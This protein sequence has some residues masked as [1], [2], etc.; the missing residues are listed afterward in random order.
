MRRYN[1]FWGLIC[2]VSSTLSGQVGRQ[3]LSQAYQLDR[4]GQFSQLI[5]VAKPLVDDPSLSNVERG[6]AAMLL[7][8]AYHQEGKFQDSASAYDRSL[9]LLGPSQ[10]N[11]LQ[12]AATLIAYG[13]LYHDM[14]R[15]GDA[16][17]LQLKALHIYE[18]DN[19]DT[20]IALACKSL[21]EIALA[22]GRLSE[23][24]KFLK[25][26]QDESKLD[27]HLNPDFFA[28]LYSIQAKLSEEEKDPAGAVAGYQ[29]ALTLLEQTHGPKHV[30]V[31]W[32]YILLGKA[33]A[34][35]GSYADALDQMRKGL[36]ILDQAM[37]PVNVHY[38]AAEMAYA[39]VLDASGAHAQAADLIK[40][41][42]SLLQDFYNG[43][44]VQCSVSVA[45]LAMK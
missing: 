14:G 31:G 19:N 35:V 30:V 13:T 10:D 43:Q 22:E 21:A 40:R 18:R 27:S 16:E 29:R 42:K 26:A 5:E 17:Q 28:S 45:A 37:G 33:N 39:R 23:G 6:Q 7:G 44:C 34:G 9:N 24:R 41:D 20:G 12:Y 38:L 15:P 1:L 36:T 4:Q 25:R 11:S 32:A 2:I 3:G 8:L